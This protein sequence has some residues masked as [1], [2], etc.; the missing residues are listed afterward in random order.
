MPDT[1]PQPTTL[2]VVLLDMTS[3]YMIDE[4]AVTLTHPTVLLDVNGMVTWPF[5]S[6]TFVFTAG[7]VATESLSDEN[8]TLMFDLWYGW[9]FKYSCAVMIDV[10]PPTRIVDGIS[11]H[12]DRIGRRNVQD[13]ES[14]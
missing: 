7:K 2:T 1:V 4:F 6:D 13:N 14:R 11:G 8:W 10:S 12:I 5:R 9:P 3:P